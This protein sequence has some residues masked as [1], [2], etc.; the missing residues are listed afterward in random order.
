MLAFCCSFREHDP[1]TWFNY[2]LTKSLA[3]PNK[4]GSGVCTASKPRAPAITC[5]SAAKGNLKKTLLLFSGNQGSNLTLACSQKVGLDYMT[6]PICVIVWTHRE[7]WFHLLESHT[8]CHLSVKSCPVPNSHTIFGGNFPVHFLLWSHKE[9]KKNRNIPL[10][11]HS[12]GV[13]DA[14]GPLQG[15]FS[16][17]LSQIT[18]QLSTHLLQILNDVQ[19]AVHAYVMHNIS[20]LPTPPCSL[21]KHTKAT[22]WS[23]APKQQRCLPWNLKTLCPSHHVLTF[24]FGTTVKYIFSDLSP[25]LYK[26]SQDFSGITVVGTRVCP[27]LCLKFT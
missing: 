23:P 17:R 5:H 7:W 20:T 4:N 13:G 8:L 1:F 19:P 15:W 18:P 11:Q 26:P 3:L 25:F 21:I 14:E 2:F 24:L 12:K 16:T 6:A 27:Q 10:Q 22:G 9:G